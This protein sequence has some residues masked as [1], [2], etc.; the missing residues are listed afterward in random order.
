MDTRVKAEG[1]KAAL[2]FFQTIV[3]FMT[4]KSVLDDVRPLTVK[5]QRRDQD[6][7]KAYKLIDEMKDTWKNIDMK[8]KSWYEEALKLAASVGV[9]ETVPRRTSYQRYRNNTPSQL[10]IDY[11]RRAVAIPLL[12]NLITQLQQR[13]TGQERHA[14]GLLCLIPSIMLG[15]EKEHQALL[16]LL[17]QISICLT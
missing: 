12:D 10:P 8:F 11:Y 6:V 4:T 13:Y 7:A 3:V 17:C 1:L 16:D 9:T 5:L 2:S 14:H 15:S